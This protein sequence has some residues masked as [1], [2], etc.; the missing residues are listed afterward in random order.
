[1]NVKESAKK[2]I[3]IMPACMTIWKKEDQSYDK[4]GQEAYIK[5]LLDNGVHSLS[6]CGSTGENLAQNFEE[7]KE[8]I[9]HVCKFVG[10]QVPI[11]VGSGQYSTINTI[12]M[13]QWAEQ[14]GADGVMVILPFYFN[15]HKKAVMHHFRELRKHIGIHIMIY[16]NPWFAGYELTVPEIK[17][18]LDEG[19]ITSIKAAHGDPNRV[20]EERYAC[21]DKLDIFYGHDYCAAEALLCGADGW[22]SGFPA[23]LPKQCVGLYNVAKD[24]MDPKKTMAFHQKHLQPF[25]NYFFYDKKDGV[26]H[27]QEICKYTLTAQGLNVGLPRAPLGDLDDENK[28]KVEKFLSEIAM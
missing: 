1:M 27:W 11:Y 2:G 22:L 7:Q 13:S 26:P 4:K 28:K 6:I 17:T 9:E 8:I 10:G 5:W 16:N 24:T 25:L 12:R 14:C 23:I 18:L 20:H 19:T 15:P 3:G 21:G